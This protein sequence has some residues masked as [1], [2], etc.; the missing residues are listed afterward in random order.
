[1]QIVLHNN[2]VFFLYLL[3]GANQERNNIKIIW[4]SSQKITEGQKS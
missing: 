4:R 3:G 1:M 2:F